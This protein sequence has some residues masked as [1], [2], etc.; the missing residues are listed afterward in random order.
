M[1]APIRAAVTARRELLRGAGLAMAVLPTIGLAG[2]GFPSS[3]PAAVHEPPAYAERLHRPALDGYVE[4]VGERRRFTVGSS[5]PAA[6]EARSDEIVAAAGDRWATD[7]VVRRALDRWDVGLLSPAA[8]DR[9]VGMATSA[10]LGDD[11]ARLSVAGALS[12]GYDPSAVRERVSSGPPPTTTTGTYRDYD[13]LRWLTRERVAAFG[14]GQVVRARGSSPGTAPERPLVAAVEPALDVL[15]GAAPPA[16]GV[17]RTLAL[18]LGTL[19]DGFV[20]RAR[21]PPG[22][23]FRDL[24]GLLGWGGASVAVEGLRQRWVGV[25]AD[26]PPVEDVERRLR[27]GYFIDLTALDRDGRVVVAEGRVDLP[28]W[29]G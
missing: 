29:L 1:P 21:L 25:F 14:A 24:D 11:R 4:D 28:V 15:A 6:V 8:V 16:T 27:S 23:V 10:P 12:G 22:P 3:G 26:A 5:R 19:G 13:L 17:D 7:G 2:C 18:L 20:V 9:W